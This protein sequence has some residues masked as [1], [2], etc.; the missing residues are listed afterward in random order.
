[1][2]PAAGMVVA[3]WTPPWL[4]ASVEVYDQR[5]K[6]TDN[7]D[8]TITEETEFIDRAT[9]AVVCRVRRHFAGDGVTPVG[10]SEI[11]YDGPVVKQA[12]FDR[13]TDGKLTKKETYYWDRI[14]RITGKTIDEY[15][16]GKLTG[17]TELGPPPDYEVLGTTEFGYDG[18]GRLIR[19]TV[20]G[21]DGEVI[22]VTAYDYFLDGSYTVT[23]TDYSTDPATVT[24]NEYT[25]GG[26]PR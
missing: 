14:G 7:P 4:L 10:G 20:R 23:V 17:R 21:D 8:G 1:M 24:R 12:T 3:A 19:I 25:A 16:S 2:A 18:Q 9:G 26:E 22:T 13:Y 5:F 15:Q 6:R 11:W